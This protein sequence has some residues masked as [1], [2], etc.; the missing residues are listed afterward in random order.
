MPIALP[1]IRPRSS[2]SDDP[3]LGDALAEFG[4]VRPRLLGIAYRILGSWSEAE[5]VVQDAWLRWQTHD[6]SV[7]LN[8]TAFLVT[9]T[10][11]LAINATKS[12]R[13]RRETYVGEWLSEPVAANHS[14]AI[15]AER[16][17]ALQHGIRLVLQRLA[18]TER[19]AYVLRRAFDY[20][21]PEI[22]TLLRISEA[23]ARQLVSRAG[24]HIVIAQRRPPSAAEH[25][26]L[27]HAFSVAAR[28]GDLSALE[29]LFAASAG[30]GAQRPSVNH[31]QKAETNVNSRANHRPRSRGVRRVRQLEPSHRAAPSS[32]H[33][34]GRRS[35]SRV[36]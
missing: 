19:A 4:N 25:Q 6:R 9:T 31:Q 2:T 30:A 14:P 13:A 21:Y 22:A 28:R 33:S 17:D 32:R 10:T 11:R 20:P 5:D 29:D 27:V 24:E 16:N 1:A 34:A 35:S 7:V 12:A 3:C 36:P 15:E 23:N 18:P 8:P 26:R